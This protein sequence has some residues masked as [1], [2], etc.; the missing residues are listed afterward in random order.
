MSD[1]FANMLRRPPVVLPPEAATQE[2][3]DAAVEEIVRAF[4]IISKYDIAS[5]VDGYKENDYDLE[6]DV[7]TTGELLTAAGQVRRFVERNPILQRP[8][9]DLKVAAL[10][11]PPGSD[12]RH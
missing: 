7:Y 10:E 12:K 6:A 8:G 11:L 2:G 5:M 1:F 3:F 4:N 9:F